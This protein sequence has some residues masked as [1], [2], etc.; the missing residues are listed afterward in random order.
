MIVCEGHSESAHGLEISEKKNYGKE[1]IDRVET[2]VMGSLLI[3]LRS[4][5]AE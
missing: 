2:V 5:R 3:Y 1:L 4:R